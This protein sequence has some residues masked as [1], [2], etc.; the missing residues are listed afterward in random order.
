MSADAVMTRV[1]AAAALTLLSSTCARSARASNTKHE[2]TPVVWDGG[3]GDCNLPVLETP[4]LT[5]HDRND[6]PLHIPYGI[7]YEDTDVAPD[8]VADSRTH[9]FFAFCRPLHRTVALPS[10]ITEADVAAG[11]AVGQVRPGSVPVADILELRDDWSDCWY[12]INADDARRPITCEMAAE[13][14]DWDV[15]DVPPGVYTIDGYVYEPQYNFWIL[16]PGVVKVHDG[17]PD[18]VGPA[19]AL[20]TKETSVYRNE[21]FTIEGCADAIDGSTFTPYWALDDPEGP[22]WVE[23]AAATPIEGDAIAFQFAPPPTTIGTLV[24][25]KI[26]VADPMGRSFTAYMADRISVINADD[27]DSCSGSFIGGGPCDGTSDGSSGPAD[28]TGGSPTTPPGETTLDTSGDAPTT[29]G[30]GGPPA[31]TPQPGGCG[32]ANGGER[33]APSVLIVL[34]VCRRRPRARRRSNTSNAASEPVVGDTLPQ[35]QP[36]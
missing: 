4:C 12:R 24:T 30:D 8:E 26:E 13:G 1:L 33:G 23:L 2:R 14:V 3:G 29:G 7:P 21:V 28:S 35:P 18:V 6:G 22:E 31:A 20:S 27:P 9:Q 16:R 11:E 17:D 10:W 19:A 15:A 36:S 32:C 25:F 5:L 34:A